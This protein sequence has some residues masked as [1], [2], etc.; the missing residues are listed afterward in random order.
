[1]V[2]LKREMTG[3]VISMG[4]STQDRLFT[5]VVKIASVNE[6]KYLWCMNSATQ[7]LAVT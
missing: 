2:F 5:L 4:H 6:L 7:I 3:C 1:M